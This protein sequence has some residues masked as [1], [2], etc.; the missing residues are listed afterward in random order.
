MPLQNELIHQDRKIA[1][2][3]CCDQS[4]IFRIKVYT[5]YHNLSNLTLHFP[6]ID[7]T[8]LHSTFIAI[9]WKNKTEN[10]AS[11]YFFVTILNAVLYFVWIDENEFHK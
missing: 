8:Y 4:I 11:Y 3:V 9:H 5:I 7:K 10:V 6:R 1:I 2:W